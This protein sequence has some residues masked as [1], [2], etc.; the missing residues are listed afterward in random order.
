MFPA[1]A[2]CVLTKL[3][4]STGLWWRS[5][6]WKGFYCFLTLNLP[7][8][9]RAVLCPCSRGM[10]PP[11][12]LL[13]VLGSPCRLHTV[14]L[15]SMCLW[16]S[17]LGFGMCGGRTMSIFCPCLFYY[18]FECGLELCVDGCGWRECAWAGQLR[19]TLPVSLL[20]LYCSFV[21]GF[22]VGVICDWVL[23]HLCSVS[24]THAVVLPS[25]LKVLSAG[26]IPLCL[27]VLIDSFSVVLAPR[28]AAMGMGWLFGAQNLT[29]FWLLTFSLRCC[30][31][32]N[33]SLRSSVD[34]YRSN[35]YPVFFLLING[36]PWYRQFCPVIFLLWGRAVLAAAPC[37]AEWAVS[38]QL[39]MSS[40]G[41]RS[42]RW[43]YSGTAPRCPS[44]ARGPSSSHLSAFQESISLLLIVRELAVFLHVPEWSKVPVAIS[45][46]EV[47]FSVL[48]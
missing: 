20:R 15:C 24:G 17:Q 29:L 28:L 40:L 11:A 1:T 32:S 4:R 19:R 25:C 35:W 37:S 2:V 9:Y 44:E 45:W 31:L 16:V 34:C 47:Q 5:P 22:S 26:V 39:P 30:F 27:N 33:I 13:Y 6:V 3:C 42:P 48:P 10:T 38:G 12:L 41:T 18:M 8:E 36:S 23:S 21:L 7:A 14:W 43:L 46:K